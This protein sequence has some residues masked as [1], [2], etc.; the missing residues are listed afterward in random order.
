MSKLL[1]FRNRH[2]ADAVMAALA[3]I[4]ASHGYVNAA[5]P[6]PGAGN[7][8]E[9]MAAIANGDLAVVQLD[10]AQRNAVIPWL[11]TRAVPPALDEAL[12]EIAAALDEARQRKT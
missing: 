1:Y 2:D 7:V 8:A 5:G 4:A 11:A 9:L 10:D 3:G 6:N 12:L